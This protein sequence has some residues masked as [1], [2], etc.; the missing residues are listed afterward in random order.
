MGAW[1]ACFLWKKLRLQIETNTDFTGIDYAIFVGASI[2]GRDR[3]R[4]LIILIGYAAI[5]AL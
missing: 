5:F 1:M 3:G 4:D 2:D